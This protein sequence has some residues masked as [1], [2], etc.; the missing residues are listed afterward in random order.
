MSKELSTAEVRAYELARL[1]YTVAAIEDRVYDAETALHIAN[2]DLSHA[3]QML[4]EAI[5]AESLLEKQEPTCP[6]T[7]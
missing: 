5:V 2:L 4:A 7:L 1:K 3:K 6:D